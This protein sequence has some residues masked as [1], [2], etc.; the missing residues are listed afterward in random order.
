MSDNVVQILK[1]T[2][3]E[4]EA[5]KINGVCVVTTK[6]DG[7]VGFSVHGNQSVPVGLIGG[8]EWAKDHILGKANDSLKAQQQ[9][10]PNK[11]AIN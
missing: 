7:T 5:G 8:M 1:D 6:N 4:A 11:D 10:K 2:M 3:K 9:P